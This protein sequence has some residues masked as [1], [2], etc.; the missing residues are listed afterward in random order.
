MY[1][2]LWRLTE[3]IGL[4]LLIGPSVYALNSF[5]G[6][7]TDYNTAAICAVGWL[8]M[9]R[10]LQTAEVNALVTGIELKEYV[11]APRPNTHTVIE[12]GDE[13][14]PIKEAL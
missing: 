6:P 3:I 5:F 8:V 1:K 7:Y 13:L 14:P 9:T 2:A 12:V 10:V 11:P 4:A